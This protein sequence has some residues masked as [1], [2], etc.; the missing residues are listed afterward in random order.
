VN[1]FKDLRNAIPSMHEPKIKSMYMNSPGNIKLELLSSAAD[2]VN[3]IS[4]V[5]LQNFCEIETSVKGLNKFLSANGL[6]N[7]ESENFTISPENKE[8]LLNRAN[9]L[10]CL[11]GLSDFQSQIYSVSNLNPILYSKVLLSF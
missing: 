4:G 7:T 8:E 2:S 1:F 11:L 6:K 10:C 5:C 9:E 3:Q